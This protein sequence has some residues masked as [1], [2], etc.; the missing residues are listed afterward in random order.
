MVREGTDGKGLGVSVQNRRGIWLGQTRQRPLSSDKQQSKIEGPT[1]KK[2]QSKVIQEVKEEK[3]LEWVTYNVQELREI[4]HGSLRTFPTLLKI[5]FFHVL[6]LIRDFSPSI[7]PSF[8]Q[9]SLLSG[10]TTF[11]FLI[12]KQSS[13]G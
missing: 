13:K 11:L 2:H 12:R 8:S 10:S 7:S 3:H 9:P 5:D 6:Y 4:K 1:Y